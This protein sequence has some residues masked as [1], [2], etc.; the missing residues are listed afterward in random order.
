M[1]NHFLVL[2]DEL[3]IAFSETK[4]GRGGEIIK[5]LFR[6]FATHKF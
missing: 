6:R 5:N 4:W 2:N 3:K 1:V